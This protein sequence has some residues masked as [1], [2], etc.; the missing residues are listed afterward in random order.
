[1]SNRNTKKYTLMYK[2]KYESWLIWRKE[3]KYE[4][5][6]F[7]LF[8]LI[9]IFD[10]Y[11]G[12]VIYLLTHFVRVQWPWRR[13]IDYRL[14]VLET[15]PLYRAFLTHPLNSISSWF[16]VLHLTNNCMAWSVQLENSRLFLVEIISRLLFPTN[17]MRQPTFR[18]HGS[19]NEDVS[20]ELVFVCS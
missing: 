3:P 11:L 7:K 10:F 1:M 17:C 20:S 5:L 18:W 13:N 8:E 19:H 15:V 16:T 2:R 12:Q 4:L 14:G 9:P 6:Y